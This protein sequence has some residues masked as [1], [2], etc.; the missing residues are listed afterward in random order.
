MGFNL[1]LRIGAFKTLTFNEEVENKQKKPSYS[2]QPQRCRQNLKLA[3]F[4]AF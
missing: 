2:F 4:K 3:S 1:E